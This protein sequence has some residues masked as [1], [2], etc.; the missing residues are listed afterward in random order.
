MIVK[1]KN[2]PN[3]LSYEGEKA[4]VSNI[5]STHIYLDNNLKMPLEMQAKAL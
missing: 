1:I 5:S 4:R 2:W 3:D